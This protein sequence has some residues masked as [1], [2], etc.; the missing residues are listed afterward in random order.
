MSEKFFL[1]L[2]C[3]YT[4]A[5]MFVHAVGCCVFGDTAGDTTK[6][7]VHGTKAKIWGFGGLVT[8]CLHFAPCKIIDG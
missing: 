3:T 6:K 7:K 5:D 4:R 8:T 2:S 1:F